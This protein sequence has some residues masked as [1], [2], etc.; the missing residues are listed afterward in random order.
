MKEAVLYSK[1]GDRIRCTA[2]ARYCLLK[3]GQTGFCGIRKNIGS[4]LYLLSYGRVAAM[5]MD[6]IEKK[7][8]YHFLPGGRVLSISTS[9]CNW[10]CKYCQ[11]YDISQRREVA[12]DYFTPEEVVKLAVE[13]GADGISYTYNEPTIFAEYAHDI[14][15]IAK[16]SGLFST[17]V[18]NGYISRE[19]I[20]YLK[21]FLDAITVDFKG[22]GND[23]F[24]RKYIG[25]G[26]YGPVFDALKLLRERGIYIEITD[27]VVPVKAVGDSLDDARRL[28]RWIRDNLG[29]NTPVHFTRFHPDYLMRNIPPTPVE[30]LEKHHSVAKEEGLRFVYIGNVPGHPLENTYCPNCGRELIRRYGFSIIEYRVDDDGKC[31]YCGEDIH[32]LMKRGKAPAVS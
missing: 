28:S 7:P 8:L 20:D 14:G 1:E 9:G 10:M 5:A 6:P 11:N 24:G 19:G 12:G 2:C 26:S 30:T 4:K 16:K 32:I 23:E 15:V 3:E 29:E 18:S 25:I 27:L 17:F 22:N 13:S 21:G 31:P